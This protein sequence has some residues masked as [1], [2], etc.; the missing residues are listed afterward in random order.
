MKHI[1]TSRGVVPPVGEDVIEATAMLSRPFQRLG[2]HICTLR[3]GGRSMLYG[4]CRHRRQSGRLAPGTRRPQSPDDRAGQRE[5]VDA[6]AR[7]DFLR[8]HVGNMRPMRWIERVSGKHLDF[9]SRIE[10]P[11]HIV[12]KKR[13][14]EAG[15]QTGEDRDSHRLDIRTGSSDNGVRGGSKRAMRRPRCRC[16][17]DE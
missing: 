14:H 15:E 3:N 10:Q 17:A 11:S 13:V 1:S 4:G 16:A 5:M 12:S 2:D 9:N 8:E 6:I 7:Q